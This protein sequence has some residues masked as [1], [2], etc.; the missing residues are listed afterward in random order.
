MSPKHE[1]QFVHG[2]TRVWHMTS[3][4][5]LTPP[6]VGETINVNGPNYIVGQT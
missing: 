1:I 6:L 3:L 2:E 4:V 5:Q